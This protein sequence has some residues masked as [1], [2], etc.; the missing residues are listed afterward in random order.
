MSKSIKSFVI[1]G[2][3][4]SL[5]CSV[6]FAETKAPTTWAPPAEISGKPAAAATDAAPAA[7]T[8]AAP[9]DEKATKEAKEKACADEATAKGLKKNK[10]WAYVG[11]CMNK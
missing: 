3:A 7:A 5:I 6:A 9:T 8:A 1:G 2:F 4:A 10:K 11:K